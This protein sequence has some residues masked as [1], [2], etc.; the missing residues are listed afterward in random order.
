MYAINL[1]F[2]ACSSRDT[3]YA[4][5]N[6][7]VYGPDPGSNPKLALAVA[8]AKRSGM[9]KATME[10]AIAKGQGVTTSGAALE[11]LTIEAMFP[12]SVAMVIEC[13]T[14]QKARTLQEV[15]Y[16]I[17]EAGGTVTPTTFLFEKKGKIVF[18]KDPE[19]RST[20]DHLESAIDAGAM[21]VDTDAD[22]RLV[23]YTEP[24][25]TKS[26]G[27][28]LSAAIGLKIESLE[29]IWDPNGDTMVRVS[30]EETLSQLDEFLDDIREEHTLQEIYMNLVRS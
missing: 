19:G 17:K 27:E 24:S 1:I 10:S 21:D 12:G 29:I 25:M 15:R 2:P 8:N 23:V 16:I 14:D 11:P 7:K 26:V 22:G 3:A 18:E 30:D 20:D 5:I 28:A 13:M 6:T 9:S 4:S